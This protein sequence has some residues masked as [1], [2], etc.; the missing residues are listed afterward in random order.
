MCDMGVVSCKILLWIC[1]WTDYIDLK[2]QQKGKAQVSEW[3]FDCLSKVN[4]QTLFKCVKFVYPTCICLG[5]MGI[6]DELT[7]P[8]WLI[9]MMKKR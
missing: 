6:G 9:Q 3:L 5:V 8:H 2:S 7:C 4:F 1:T